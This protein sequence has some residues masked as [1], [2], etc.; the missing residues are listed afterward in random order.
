MGSRINS[1]DIRV[2]CIAPGFFDTKSTHNSLNKFQINHL[3]KNTPLKRLGKT[4]ELIL[5]IDFIIK[6][7]F[8]NGKV[9]SLDGGLE[10]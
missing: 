6:N 2:A 1:F 4:K 3:R 10:L 8:F 9:L 5:A 7:E